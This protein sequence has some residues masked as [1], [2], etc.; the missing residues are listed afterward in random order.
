MRR[1]ARRAR[2]VP[3]AL[4][5]L[6][7][8]LAAGAAACARAER[9]AGA[10]PAPAA[11]PASAAASSGLTP[12]DPPAAPGAMAPYPTADGG[13]LVMTWLEPLPAAAEGEEAHALR[14][15]RLSGDRWSQPVTIASGPDFFANWAD[16]PGAAALAPRRTLVA[17][18]LGKVA[19][20]TY[21]YGVHLAR[22]NDA[23][24]TWQRLSSLHPD[25]PGP[26][27]HGFVSYAA[28]GNALRAFWLDGRQ[29][30]DDGPMTLRTTQIDAT[31][32]PGELLDPRVCD[33]C[34]TDA[35]W[36]SAGPVVVYRDR[37]DEEIRDIAIVRRTATGWTAPALVHADTWR[38]PGCP[39]NGPAVAAAGRRVAVAW[40]TAAPPG[41]R[42]LA[43]FSDDAG[44][45]FAPPIEIDGDRPLGR[46]DL[47]LTATGDAVVSWLAVEGQGAKVRLRRLSAAGPGAPFSVAATSATR[48]SGFPRMALQDDRLVL[49]WVEDGEPSRL[50]AASLPL[51]AL[52]PAP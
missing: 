27:E 34:Q 48:S 24:A 9:S 35:A 21:A 8:V 49:A 13:E 51:A 43:A 5:A 50:R 39:V 46:V 17:H 29:M 19:D 12:L 23:G 14:F 38:I 26:T 4:V 31:V 40:F 36:T 3:A 52:P 16:F 20:D 11:A 22:S 10:D 7:A 25:D 41:A 6:T 30:A 28:D 15:A 18:W 32:Q 42:V 44:A 37:S 2:T 45:T 1:G 47:A 33:C